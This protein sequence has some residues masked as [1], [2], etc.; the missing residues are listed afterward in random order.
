MFALKLDTLNLQDRGLSP[1]EVGDL[2]AL[3]VS[4]EALSPENS[5]YVRSS[6]GKRT[7][8]FF[9]ST[10]A[11]TSNSSRPTTPSGTY[12]SVN[13]EQHEFLSAEPEADDPESQLSR[14]GSASAALWIPIKPPSRYPSLLQKP[15]S[16][17][18]RAS[19]ASQQQPVHIP[20]V[21]SPT[22]TT[23]PPKPRSIPHD[24]HENSM[25]GQVLAGKYHIHSLIGSGAFSKVVLASLLQPL[26]DHNPSSP[27]AI[28][29]IHKATTFQNQRMQLAVLRETEVLKARGVP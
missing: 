25:S 23:S 17:S 18:Q 21:S 19:T 8:D 22:S 4:A 13:N 5:S 6:G 11:S 3:P 20:R 16:S 26:S 27:V 14:S 7:H 28:K 1:S 9:S 29:L 12:N 15:T 2:T 24:D 10:S